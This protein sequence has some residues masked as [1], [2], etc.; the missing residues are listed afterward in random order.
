MVLATHFS[1]VCYF[2]LTLN[3]KQ[4]EKCR[5]DLPVNKKCVEQFVAPLQTHAVKKMSLS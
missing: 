3:I 5:A 2:K 1:I 4:E